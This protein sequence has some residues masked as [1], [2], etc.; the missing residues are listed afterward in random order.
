[1]FNMTKRMQKHKKELCFL[2]RCSKEQR[3]KLL[4]TAP[5]SLVHAVGDCAKSVLEG[6][7]PISNYYR[8]KLRKDINILKKLATRNNSITSKKKILK[9]QKGSSII[10][11]LWRVLKGLF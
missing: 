5:S 6:D 1:M 11:V 4:N 8:K 9:S 7:L 10:G 2:S 3:Y